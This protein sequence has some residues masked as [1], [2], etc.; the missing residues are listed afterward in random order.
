MTVG[1]SARSDGPPRRRILV[2]R[3]GAV[4]D[5]IRLLPVLTLIRRKEPEATIA[6]VSE[7][8]PSALL[9]GHPALDELIVLPRR[10]I[11]LLLSRPRTVL[12]GLVE[13]MRF[14]RALRRGRWDVVLDFHGTLKSGLVSAVSGAPERWGYEPPGSKE[15]NR[16]FN[17]RR[18]AIPAG[19]LHRIERNLA[20]VRAFG[21]PG[22]EV[23]VEL[24]ITAAHRER[25]ARWWEEQGLAGR[26]AVLLYPG[27]SRRQ[28]WKRPPAELFG[29]TG[30]RLAENPGIAVLVA[31][32]PGEEDLVRQVASADPVRLRVVP[33]LGLLEL[34]ELV[35][36]CRLFLGPDTGPMHLAWAVGCPV[37]AL[38]GPTDPRINSPWGTG[39]RVLY[40][41]LSQRGGPTHWPAAD[42]IAEAARAMLGEA[43][44]PPNLPGTSNGAAG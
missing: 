40:N 5:V 21:A 12:R 29:E 11:G 39:H 9:A 33:T 14:A 6:W 22:D 13:T 20:L 1:P 44:R 3:L 34:A 23:R 26:T 38:F 31:G 17:N 36:R 41:V 35:R 19:P 18:V 10:S 27:T 30:R 32:G 2:I 4:G 28:S 15:G 24:P 37:L 7:E 8:A 16:L 42:E 25:I 43:S